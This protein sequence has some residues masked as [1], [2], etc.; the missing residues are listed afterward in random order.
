MKKGKAKKTKWTTIK[1]RQEDAGMAATPIQADASTIT[2]SGSYS[3]DQPL[4]TDQPSTTD[5]GITTATVSWTTTTTTQTLGAAAAMPTRKAAVGAA[6]G[7]A[8]MA[9]LLI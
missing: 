8:G 6:V 3:S 1:K 2:L 7:A 5:P 9:A 4:T